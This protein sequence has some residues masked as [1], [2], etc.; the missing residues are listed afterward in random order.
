MPKSRRIELGTIFRELLGSTNVYFQPSES[1]KIKYPC[2]IYELSDLDLTHA[3]NLNY[4]KVPRY[5]VKL[6]TKDPDFPLIEELPDSF[7]MCRFD[8]HYVAENLHH[9]TYSI[10]Y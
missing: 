1:T 8:R 4:R 2:I 10:Y 9:Y 5:E 6:I 3:D 7:S